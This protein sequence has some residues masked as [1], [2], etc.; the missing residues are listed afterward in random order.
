M[1]RRGPGSYLL[2]LTGVTV[3]AAATSLWLPALGLASSALLFLLPVLLVAARGGIGP[4]LVAAGAGALA[5]NYFLLPPRFTLRIHGFDNVVSVLVL[6]AVAL[7]TSRLAMA[8]KHREAEARSRAEASSEAA[9]FAALLGRGVLAEGIGTALEWLRERYGQLRLIAHGSLP[10]GDPGL[11]TLDLS[12]AAW[13]MHNGD[14]TGHGTTTMP[15]ADW[16]FLPL[17]PGGQGGTDLLAIARPADG[18][19]RN[20]DALGQLSALSRLVGQGRDRLAL[21]QE[22][23]ARERLEDRDA[24]GRTLLASLAHDFRT[25]LTVVAGELERLSHD[26]A[27]AASALAEAR[28]LDR[29]MDD[30]IGAARIESGTL[31]PHLEAVDLVDIVADGCAAL[32]ALLEPLSVTRDLPIDLPLAEAEPVLLRH[33][34]INLLANAARHAA[35][36]IAVT[37]RA[38]NGHVELSVS[39]DGPGIPAHERDRIFQ[40]FASIEAGDRH[41]GSG[42]GLAIVKGFADAMGM[43]IEVTETPGGGS[44]FRLAMRARTANAP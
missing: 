42:L 5:Y 39:D 11:S 18:T 28:R 17:A 26:D 21:E 27:G 3:V 15:S 20:G 36:A 19:T 6:F 38:A 29:M 43:T 10:E 24:L 34:L 14:V 41:G 8:L 33:I 7:V 4:G 32:S 37:A 2:A 44:T 13:A 12:A 25:P 31:S 1:T 22:R 23:R 35:G 16:T 40:R 9:A 30:L